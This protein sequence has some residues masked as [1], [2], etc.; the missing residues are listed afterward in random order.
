MS[1]LGCR[2]VS[3]ESRPDPANP[4]KYTISR[5]QL[6]HD[7]FH[8]E[9]E[10]INLVQRVLSTGYLSTSDTLYNPLD[11][12]TSYL[13]PYSGVFSIERGLLERHKDHQMAL[14]MGNFRIFEEASGT[15]VFDIVWEWR[16][17][18]GIFV[19]SVTFAADEHRIF[20]FFG[21]KL[22]VVHQLELVLKEWHSQML[23]FAR[24]LLLGGWE[25]LQEKISQP[26]AHVE[27]EWDV[28]D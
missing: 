24:R 15:Q 22:S 20:Q 10:G 28:L 16:K 9:V 23:H 5:C 25:P 21:T 6:P 27:T 8:T 1:V 13:R 26:V 18:Q 14:Y 11:N 3:F 19:T 17:G 2:M 4:Y 7:D 12:Q